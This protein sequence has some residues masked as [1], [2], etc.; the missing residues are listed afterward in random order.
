VE[1]WT[2]IVEGSDA[3]TIRMGKNIYSQNPSTD[4]LLLRLFYFYPAGKRR[5]KIDEASLLMEMRRSI[6]V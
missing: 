3:V 4:A 6:P 2:K 1:G 5:S